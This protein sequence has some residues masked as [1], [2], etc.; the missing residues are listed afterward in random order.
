MF[1]DFISPKLRKS[2]TFVTG[3]QASCLHE[4]ENAK[5]RLIDQA[6]FLF[7]HFASS[8]TRAGRMPAVQS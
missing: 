3:T 8:R 4:R 6:P 7:T 2:L 1:Q 5:R